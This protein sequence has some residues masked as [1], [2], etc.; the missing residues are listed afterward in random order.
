MES[1]YV[2]TLISPRRMVLLKERYAEET[3]GT[4]A[5]LL[6]SGLD[7]KWWVDSVECCH[8]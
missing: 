1:L 5:V 3:K 7:E 6:P 2:N 8:L 4:S